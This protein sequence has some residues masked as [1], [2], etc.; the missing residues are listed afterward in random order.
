MVFKRKKATVLWLKGTNLQLEN[1]QEALHMRNRDLI[2][3]LGKWV[4]FTQVKNIQYMKDEKEKYN[5]T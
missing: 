5:V 1:N 3:S 2:G 4:H